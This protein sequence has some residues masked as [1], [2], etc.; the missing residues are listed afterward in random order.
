MVSH[1]HEMHIMYGIVTLVQ[2]EVTPTDNRVK[3]ATT[4]GQCC[5]KSCSQRSKRLRNTTVNSQVTWGGSGLGTRL[6]GHSAER[7]NLGVATYRG[8]SLP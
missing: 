7:C 5:S 1:T 2:G 8:V 6:S 4:V 3:A